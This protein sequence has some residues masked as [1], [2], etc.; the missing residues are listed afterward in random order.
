[1]IDLSSG[2]V[3]AFS[4]SMCA[5]LMVLLAPEEMK[6]LYDQEGHLVPLSLGI[7]ALAILGTI[8]IGFL[9]GSLHAWLI[10]VVGLPPFIATLATLVGL[11]SFARIIVENVTEAHWGGKSTQIQIYDERFRY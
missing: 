9:I 6:P 4:G 7:I 2:S 5:T 11:R 10:T 8:L 3:I 1:G